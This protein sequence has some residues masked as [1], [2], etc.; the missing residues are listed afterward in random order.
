VRRLQREV[1]KLRRQREI[2]KNVAH[3]CRTAR[4][5]YER[6]AAMSAEHSVS[7]L[8]AVLSV[9]RSGYR[10]WQHQQEGARAQENW[11]LE[12]RHTFRQ[13]REVYGSPR[14][15]VELRAQG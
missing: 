10:A 11:R 1:A 4:E 14:L 6:I 9:S 2:L 15:A 12:I 7:L 3:P 13:Q 8:C 5:H